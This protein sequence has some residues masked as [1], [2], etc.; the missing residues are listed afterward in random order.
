MINWPKTPNPSS[1]SP[2]DLTGVFAFP[3]E[4]SL[5][6]ITSRVYPFVAAIRR[7]VRARLAHG[8]QPAYPDLVNTLIAEARRMALSKGQR[9]ASKGTCVVYFLRLRSG[10]LYIGA[11]DDLEQRLGDHSSGQACRTTRFDP[12]AFV[13]RVE[14]CSTFSEARTR[15]AQLKRWSRPKKEALIRGDAQTLRALSRS[16]DQPK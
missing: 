8:L 1:R 15:E 2:S 5:H 16:H 13:L 4:K 7:A 10:A 11:T 3:G 6:Y 9:P 14:F 12:P